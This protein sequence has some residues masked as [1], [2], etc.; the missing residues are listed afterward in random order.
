MTQPTAVRRVPDTFRPFRVLD[1]YCCIGGGTKGIKRAI[2][3][4]HV[5][6]VDIQAQPDYC[7]DAFHQGDAIEF[8]REHGHE[9]DFIHAYLATLTPTLGVAA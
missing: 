7:G 9:F 2:P 4:V 5:T 3:G 8:I 1:A 6:G